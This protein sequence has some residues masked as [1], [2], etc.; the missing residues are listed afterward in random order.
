MGIL[1]LLK[2]MVEQTV[3]KLLNTNNI[4]Y[5]IILTPKAKRLDRLM[6]KGNFAQQ[7]WREFLWSVNKNVWK[8]CFYAV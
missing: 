5:Q 2:L 7:V 8:K 3:F 4:F 1:F 6:P